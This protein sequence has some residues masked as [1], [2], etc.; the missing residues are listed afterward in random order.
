MR[1]LMGRLNGGT[2]DVAR[3]LVSDMGHIY[4]Y[5][6]NRSLFTQALDY[7]VVG[8]LLWV[9]FYEPDLL[10]AID[11]WSGDM[12]LYWLNLAT[13]T[14]ELITISTSSLAA[15]YLEFNYEGTRIDNLFEIIEIL[16]VKP[17]GYGPYYSIFYPASTPTTTYIFIIYKLTNQVLAYLVAYIGSLLSFIKRQEISTFNL[18]SPLATPNAAAASEIALASNNVDLYVSNRLTSDPTDS[19]SYFKVNPAWAEPLALISLYSSS[20]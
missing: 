3:V 7:T 19:I 16:R 6:Y 10:Y 15:M 2:H 18:Y 17:A 12:S 4:L 13:N 20:G 9:T 11:E 8:D 5:D 1:F 14:G